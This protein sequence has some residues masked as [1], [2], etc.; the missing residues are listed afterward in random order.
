MHYLLLYDVG[1]DYMAR[2]A[3]FRDEHLRLAWAAAERNEL[4]LGG[5]LGDP[6]EGA[7]LLFRS[8]SPQVA[9]EFARHD[10]YVVNGLVQ[11]WRVVPWLTVVGPDAATPVKP[12]NHR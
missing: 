6:L 7:A 8:E 12:A 5:A 2:R 9:Q 4:V 1:P 10:P 11:R 3:Q